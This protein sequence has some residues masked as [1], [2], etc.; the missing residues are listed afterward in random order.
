MPP[1]NIELEPNTTRMA[2]RERNA[3]VHPGV[4]L[5]NAQRVRRT[6]EEI[7]REKELKRIRAEAKAQKKATSDDKKARGEARIAQLQEIE[8]ASIANANSEFPRRKL[9][10]GLQ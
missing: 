10:K 3:T 9:K 7:E 2:T 6:K 1:N 8:D 5:K 4:V